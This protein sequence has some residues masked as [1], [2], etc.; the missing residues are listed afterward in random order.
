MNDGPAAVTKLEDWGLHPIT[1]PPEPRFL[2]TESHL[3]NVEGL[4]LIRGRTFLVSNQS[5]DLMPPGAP[6]VGLFREDTRYLSQIEL[7][8]NGHPPSVLSAT[9]EGA[10]A[11]RVEL[12]VK[13]ILPGKGLDI[14][15]NTVFL[16]RE[17]ILESEGLYDILQ[18]QNFHSD[19]AHLVVE[20]TYDS[21]FMD[22]FQVRGIIRGKSGR[23]FE[24]LITGTQ[25]A[26]VYEG[27]DERIRTT[28]LSFNPTPTRISGHTSRWELDLEPRGRAQINAAIVTQVSSKYSLPSIF[29]SSST[30]PPWI[31][32]HESV[33][34]HE[35]KLHLCLTSWETDCTQ[36]KS[37]NELFNTMLCTSLRDFYSLQI[38]EGANRTIAAGVPWFAALFGRD[39]IISSFQTLA[40]NPALA[41][42]TLRSLAARQGQVKCA[43]ND[44]QPGKIL[45][46]L[47]SGEMTATGE[48]AFGKNYGSVDA[49]PLFIILL[50]EYFQWTGDRELLEEMRLPLSSALNWLI[51]YGDMD[52]DGLIEYCRTTD[53]GLL[54]QGWKDSGDAMAHADGTLAQAPIALVEEQGYAADAFRRAATM[55]RL[56]GDPDQADRLMSRADELVRK[57]DQSFWLE[58]DAYYA[59]A[60]DRD[61]QQL[62]VMS[63]NP[64]HLLFSHTI[65]DERAGDVVTKL[66]AQG[67]FSG[68][69]IRT[70]SDEEQTYNPMSYHRG[71]VW[72][73]DN[74]LIA[75]GMARYGYQQE[76]SA[77]L[78]ALFEASLHFREYR[79]PELFCGNQRHHRDEPVHYPV[80]CSPQAWASGTPI[81]ILAALLGLKPDA[82]GKELRIVNPRLP[83]FLTFLEVR[84]LRVGNSQIDM[85]FLRQGDRTS[86]R[87]VGRKGEDMTVSITHP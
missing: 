86:C 42:G 12:T 48:V 84:N 50:S 23:Y 62:A 78:S 68:W 81:V 13:G 35:E 45:H 58:G 2:Y 87:V 8:V 63:S 67:L 66:M 52:G 70:L 43:D 6:N 3:T 11:N 38:P 15:V 9:T 20:I 49:T 17:Q 75:F 14:P 71:S 77:I 37:N 26:F 29:T 83:E 44:E 69:G 22:I 25:M 54:N 24:P 18:I 64:G 36:F 79:L 61:K 80:S 59:M 33:E 34:E 5:G 7:L 74:S 73:H 76:A 46:E 60:L 40:L 39:S 72:P 32:E 57:L 4:A 16:H 55:M 51:E 56:L 10:Y 28:T 41:R 1:A 65:T 27:L 30:L 82:S 85:D 31:S 21:D 19:T 53:K 47:R